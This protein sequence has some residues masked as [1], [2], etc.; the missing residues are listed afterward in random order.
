MWQRSQKQTSILKRISQY[1]RRHPLKQG[2]Q[3]RC[4]RRKTRLITSTD[5]C[6]ASL[7]FKYSAVGCNRQKQAI[8]IHFIL[9][10]VVLFLAIIVYIHMIMNVQL[11][12][13]KEVL[14]TCLPATYAFVSDKYKNTYRSTQS[15]EAI[16][17]YIFL[18]Y[19]EQAV[20]SLTHV[21]IEHIVC[22]IYKCSNHYNLFDGQAQLSAC[23][24]ILLQFLILIKLLCQEN[25]R[26]I[27]ARMQYTMPRGGGG[28]K[29]HNHK[30]YVLSWHLHF[31]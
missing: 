3:K 18:L 19:L 26:N 9:I 28:T 25:I 30:L 2:S 6:I 29:N 16:F 7:K 15:Y 21:F 24:F 14:K 11:T 5:S 20:Y 8:S 27:D 23:C 13:F 17:Y 12:D 31:A 10:G 1:L 22:P 4:K